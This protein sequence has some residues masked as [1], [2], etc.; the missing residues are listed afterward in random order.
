MHTPQLSVGAD[1]SQGPQLSVGSKDDH[2]TLKDHSLVWIR[3][4]PQLSVL[5]VGFESDKE[6]VGTTHGIAQPHTDCSSDG[7]TKT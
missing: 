7:P 5:I 4:G 6:D 2:G 3:K 1:A